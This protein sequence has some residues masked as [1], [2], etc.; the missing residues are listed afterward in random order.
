MFP[1]IFKNQK[2]LPKIETKI[3]KKNRDLKSKKDGTYRLRQDPT[4]KSKIRIKFQKQKQRIQKQIPIIE[5]DKRLKKRRSRQYPYK[6]NTFEYLPNGETKISK[7]DSEEIHQ[8][9]IKQTGY[10]KT[11]K[12][13]S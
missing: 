5:M 7:I 1:K 6:F 11:R 8:N 9:K 12:Q 13:T 2:K 10:D 3:A 4:T